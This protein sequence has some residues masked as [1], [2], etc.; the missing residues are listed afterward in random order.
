MIPLAY[1]TGTSSIGGGQVMVGGSQSQT[2][3]FWVQDEQLPAA[4]Q[5]VQVTTVV[6]TGKHAGASLATLTTPQLSLTVGAPRATVA[7]QT[8]GSVHAICVNSMC[9]ALAL[10]TQVCPPSRLSSVK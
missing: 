10:G 2:V 8:P 5:A 6:P 7:Q 3:I 1:T 4:S 9:I